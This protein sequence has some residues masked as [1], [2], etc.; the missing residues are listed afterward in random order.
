MNIPNKKWMR[1]GR[2]GRAGLINLTQNP[3]GIAFG[4]VPCPYQ[5]LNTGP[6]ER[7]FFGDNSQLTL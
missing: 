7:N 1:I 6:T 2:S 3:P 4:S 5:Y